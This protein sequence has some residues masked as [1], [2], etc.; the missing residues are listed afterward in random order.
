MHFCKDGDHNR[1]PNKNSEIGYFY[2]DC[3]H[4]RI[5]QLNTTGDILSL[6]H[7]TR[8]FFKKKEVTEAN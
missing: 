7:C 8:P 5:Y 3:D 1:S 4:G 2:E 6:F